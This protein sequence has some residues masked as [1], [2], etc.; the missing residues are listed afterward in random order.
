MMRK[1][2]MFNFKPPTEELDKERMKRRREGREK[3]KIPNE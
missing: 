2:K 3:K 1:S